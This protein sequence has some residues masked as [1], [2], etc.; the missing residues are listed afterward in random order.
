MVPFYSRIWALN[1]S[2]FACASPLAPFEETRDVAGALT[3]L[4][5]VILPRH[6][7][8][9]IA[10]GGRRTPEILKSFMLLAATAEPPRRALQDEILALTGIPPADMDFLRAIAAV[11][12]V[13]PSLP[14]P[15]N[16]LRLAAD[17]DLAGDFDLVFTYAQQA[18]PSTQ[19]TRMLFRCAMEVG[20]LAVERAA[21]DALQAQD[22][23][24][25]NVF[26]QQRNNRE[27]YDRIVGRVGGVPINW[28]DWLER[29]NQDEN[30][31]RALEV[32]RQGSVEWDIQDFLGIPRAGERFFELLVAERSS[33]AQQRIQEALPFL[34]RFFLRDDAWPRAEFTRLY[35]NLLD[36]LAMQTD[37]GDQDLELFNELFR[38]LSMLGLSAEGYADLV[39]Y[40]REFWRRSASASKLDWALDILDMLV[41]EPCPD[42]PARQQFFYDVAG[43]IKRFE[44]RVSI[45][46]WYIFDLLCADLNEPVLPRSAPAEAQAE[47]SATAPPSPDGKV[48]GLYTLTQSVGLR[49][50]QLLE[51]QYSGLEVRLNSDKAG[52]DA[53]RH[54]AQ[55]ADIFI[56]VTQSAKHAATL[57]IERHL[58]KS[59]PLLRPTGKGVSAIMR[60]LREHLMAQQ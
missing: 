17:A 25:R 43:G 47:T 54:L 31:E 8:L 3:H 15:P 41:C 45:S 20:T 11:G 51:K 24:A 38:S 34:L 44:R 2:P 58:P 23:E 19:R 50:K 49:A 9:F 4:K 5:Q 6:G 14:G 53:L 52:T 42:A 29:L 22:E 28:I 46:Q 32:A 56:M 18:Q 40:A 57:F 35:A 60:Q 16:Y 39:G 13:E 12:M 1:R 7:P 33:E 27:F 10:R 21:V 26:L 59:T 55:G 36:L 48:I 37:C 30:W